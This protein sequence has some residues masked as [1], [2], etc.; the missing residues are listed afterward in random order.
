MKNLLLFVG[1]SVITFFTSCKKQPLEPIVGVTPDITFNNN[2]EIVGTK[3]VLLEYRNTAYIGSTKSYDTITFISNTE[4]ML[5]N[6]VIR[7]Y[8]ISSLV[9][10]TNKSLQLNFFG[11]FGGS[12]Y[13]GSVGQ[14]FVSDGF[15]N[16]CLFTDNQNNSIKFLAWFE[17]IK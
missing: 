6:G 13:S 16:A 10:S 1:L 17:R 2:D 14:Y 12:N 7:T 15:I 3:W 9:G 8:N 5:N 4:Y 11:P